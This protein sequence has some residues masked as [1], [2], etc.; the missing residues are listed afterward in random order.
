MALLLTKLTC[1]F[2][3]PIKSLRTSLLAELDLLHT[4][5]ALAG[6]LCY[7]YYYQANVALQAAAMAAHWW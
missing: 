2:L 1:L 5:L 6:T 3:A 7:Y 4:H